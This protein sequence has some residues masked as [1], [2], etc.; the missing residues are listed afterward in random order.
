[1]YPA[2]LF[3]SQLWLRLLR[4]RLAA[5]LSLVLLATVSVSAIASALA[6]PVY[7]DCY[8]LLI[9]KEL[10][11]GAVQAAHPDRP[12]FGWL[13]QIVAPLV[14]HPVALAVLNACCWLAFGALAAAVAASLLGRRFVPAAGVL[15]VA[16]LVVQTQTTTVTTCF[17]A[18]VPVLLVLVALLLLLPA[19]GRGGR[20]GAVR[21]A[22]AALFLIAGVLISEYAV[23]A[24]AASIS[25]LGVLWASRRP[26]GVCAGAPAI[27]ALTAAGTAAYF[28]FAA[29]S[30]TSVRP[31]VVPQLRFAATPPAEVPFGILSGGWYAVAGAYGRAAA[32][33]YIT[34]DSK[35]TVL[36]LGFGLFIAVLLYFGGRREKADNHFA[37]LPALLAALAMGMLPIV[38]MGRSLLPESAV[39]SRFLLPVLP[40]AVACTLYL[41]SALSK[42]AVRSILIATL[43]LLAGFATV[44]TAAGQVR[45][46]NV[47]RKL[48]DFLLER[49]R[50]RTGLTVVVVPSPLGSGNLTAKITYAWPG[51]ESRRLWVLNAEDARERF[52]PRSACRLPSAAGMQP[53]LRWHRSGHIDELAWMDLRDDHIAGMQPY[54]IGATAAAEITPAPVRTP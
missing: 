36:A 49:N 51:T 27:I 47:A 25:L 14:L 34:W 17:A 16:P 45:E 22:G 32:A 52:G 11:R 24:A 15:S 13:L 3:H 33:L 20:P 2:Q 30:N 31:E 9:V 1:M 18:N 41:Y 53:S 44:Q 37:A 12:I 29:L 54:C 38:F 39:R 6:F 46:Q 50:G 8:L 23:A 40:F 28:V 35:S 5:E 7:D 10:G 48:G 42:P 26:G 4:A 21:L 43:G 19:A